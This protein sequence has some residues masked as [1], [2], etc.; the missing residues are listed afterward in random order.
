M[1]QSK[2][3]W[4]K[5]LINT[6]ELV[7]SPLQKLRTAPESSSRRPSSM[8]STRFKLRDLSCQLVCNSRGKNALKETKGSE[9][10]RNGKSTGKGEAMIEDM[11]ETAEVEE[12]EV[13][14]EVTE[15]EEAEE[16]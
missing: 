3:L 5:K 2:S 14:S 15:E 1:S 11:I 9:M 16:R 10:P 7:S 6:K 13:I 4:I 12:V 8:S